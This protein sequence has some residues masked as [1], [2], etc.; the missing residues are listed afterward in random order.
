MDEKSSI[1]MSKQQNKFNK[2][3]KG[4]KKEN[5]KTFPRARQV[6]KQKGIPCSWARKP[7]IMKISFS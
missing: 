6:I 2:D 1:I 3:V 5:V 4:L 7:D